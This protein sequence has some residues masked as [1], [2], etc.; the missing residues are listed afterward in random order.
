MTASKEYADKWLNEL[1]HRQSVRQPAKAWGEIPD[2]PIKP[3]ENYEVVAA[4]SH[5]E[6]VELKKRIDELQDQINLLAQVCEQFM[7][8][9]DD[10]CDP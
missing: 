10:N 4:H 7:D 5:H 8:R 6:F 3:R 1:E 2:E 9:S